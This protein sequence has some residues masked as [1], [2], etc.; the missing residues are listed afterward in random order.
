MKYIRFY[1]RWLVYLLA[2]EEEKTL[3]VL[4]QAKGMRCVG[5]RNGIAKYDRSRPPQK[6][7]WLTWAEY[8]AMWHPV[9]GTEMRAKP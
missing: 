9:H 5:W 3:Y 6:R 8:R 4:A 1:F 7:S 2:V